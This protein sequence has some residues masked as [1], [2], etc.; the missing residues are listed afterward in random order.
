MQAA[1]DSPGFLAVEALLAFQQRTDG[2]IHNE[3]R[4][5]QR[6]FLHPVQ[7][8]HEDIVFI[9]G[10]LLCIGEDQ[11]TADLTAGVIADVHGGCNLQH[12]L[13]FPLAGVGCGS[14][15]R[16]PE[17]I[18][19]AVVA[20]PIAGAEVLM[21]LV[22]EHTPAE[23]ARVLPA[24]VGRVQHPQMPHGLLLPLLPGVKGFGGEHMT[25]VLGNQEGA[26][27]VGRNLG[28][29]TAAIIGAHMGKIIEGIHILQQAALFHA[30]DAGGCPGGVQLVGQLVCLAVEGIVVL[31]LVDADAPEDDAGMVAVLLHHLLHIPAC[32]LLPGAVAD[33]LPA[34]DLHEH[35]QAQAVAL[36]DEILA[37]GVVAGAHRIAV[38]LLLENAGILP[39]Q[40]FGGCVADVGEALVPVQAPQEA[41]FPIEIKT[42]GPELGGTETEQDALLV[43][44]LLSVHQLHLADIPAGAEQS[45]GA[46]GQM[47]TLHP[48]LPAADLPDLLPFFTEDGDQVLAGEVH[49]IHGDCDA[50]HHG[51]YHGDI[52]DMG[53]RLLN[54]PSLPVQA[55][56]G[57][58]VHHKA[59]GRYGRI[60]GGV[61]PDGNGV[62]PGLDE[63]RDVH[64]EGGIAAGVAPGL[65]TVDID[66]GNVG[67]AVKLQQNAFS[68]GALR[69]I[70]LSAVTADALIGL[71][72]GIVQ[73]QLHGIVGQR[74][75]FGRRRK[76]QEVLAPLRGEL[77][78]EANTGFHLLSSL[79]QTDFRERNKGIGIGHGGMDPFFHPDHVIPSAEFI[80]AAFVPS[81]IAEAQSLMETGTV[82]A[83]IRIVLPVCTGDAGI[84]HMDILFCQPLLQG[85]IQALPHSG[86][87][88]VPIHIDGQ[89]HPML[90]GLPLLEGASIGIAHDPAFVLGDQVRIAFQRPGDPCLKLR[91]AGDG[92]L[93]G[94]RGMLHIRA[95]DFQKARGIGRGSN[96]NFHDGSPHDKESPAAFRF[97]TIILFLYGNVKR[98]AKNHPRRAKGSPA[99]IRC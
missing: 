82:G 50:V 35:Q 64:G 5:G 61:Q 86:P 15:L 87:A 30:A 99:G 48:V 75:Q 31:A 76:I 14:N 49:R 68:F 41:F 65:L 51:G 52:P 96:A 78:I 56:V 54:E 34:G 23:A 37:L 62:F 26:L 47:L 2:I 3:G 66:G 28:L 27:P 33:M 9:E 59:E 85:R 58:V 92:I 8:G 39:L 13:P 70:Q 57:Q 10:H 24:G 79:S 46:G 18:H 83:E 32:L 22:I 55:A 12:S 94:H 6:G 40:G 44:L 43:H 53:G 67:G 11:R 81:C 84:E 25:I 73:R 91:E 72:V 4:M 88:A 69:Q 21:G 45:P 74:H 80:A 95:I 29:G 16:I 98:R 36:V 42:V 97:L 93:K 71:M 19:D 20:D 7:L 90:I 77:P 38:Q 89:L 17:S 1:A 63:F 60:L